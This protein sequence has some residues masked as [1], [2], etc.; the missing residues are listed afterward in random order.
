MIL[1][2]LDALAARV[3]EA[4]VPV[5]Q[6]S[7]MVDAAGV[8]V[9]VKPPF[10]LVDMPPFRRSITRVD[11]RQAH[12]VAVVQVSCIHALP[13]AVLDLSESVSSSLAGWTP[14]VVGARVYPVVMYSQPTYPRRDESLPGRDLYITHSTWKVEA[15]RL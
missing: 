9:D 6:R 2:L 7:D 11:G 12:C 1:D 8:P 3:A 4:G 10:L 13:E 14:R 5:I 15:V